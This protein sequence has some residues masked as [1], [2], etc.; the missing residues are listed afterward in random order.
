MCCS[1][2]SSALIMSEY[3]AFFNVGGMESV[4]PVHII[5]DIMLL[6]NQIYLHQ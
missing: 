4:L 1:L 3:N 5:F 2:N 6:Y